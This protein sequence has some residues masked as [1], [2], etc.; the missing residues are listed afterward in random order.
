M[1]RTRKKRNAVMK[2]KGWVVAVDRPRDSRH[3]RSSLCLE[4]VDRTRADRC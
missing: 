4:I 1:E 2:A 3:R